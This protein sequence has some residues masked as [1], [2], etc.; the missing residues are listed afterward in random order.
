MR[1]NENEYVTQEFRGAGSKGGLTRR[2]FLGTAALAGL[3]TAA[4]GLVGCSSN[5]GSS[6]AAAAA[7][8]TKAAD[9]V[10]A[11]AADGVASNV[12]EGGNQAYTAWSEG[13]NPQR[14][15]FRQTPGDLSHVLSPWKLCDWEFSN[16]IVKSA[17]GSGYIFG[18]WDIFTE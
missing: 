10:T 6:G 5:Q 12:T 4:A 11:Q 3:A 15:D 7:D 16:R 13:I 9:S 8:S 17:A 18:G 2:S 1:E 14:D